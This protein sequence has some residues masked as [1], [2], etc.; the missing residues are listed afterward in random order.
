M[1][2]YLKYIIIFTLIIIFSVL[3]APITGKVAVGLAEL[4]TLGKADCSVWSEE[5]PLM[6][7]SD[8]PVWLQA[9]GGTVIGETFITSKPRS[10]FTDINIAH[11]TVHKLQQER[12]GILFPFLY[13]TQSTGTD[14]CTNSFE[15]EAGYADGRY[16][17]CVGKEKY[18]EK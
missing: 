10:L 1:K 15:E 18:R 16:V 9:K 8:A 4:G 7:C 14:T 12:Y 13:F 5:Q 17:N 3:Y 2:K 11:E 6:V